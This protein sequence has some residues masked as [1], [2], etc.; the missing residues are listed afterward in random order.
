MILLAN[1][2]ASALEF[3]RFCMMDTTDHHHAAFFPPFNSATPIQGAKQA[4]PSNQAKQTGQFKQLQWDD[5]REFVDRYLHDSHSMLV[6]T[7][8]F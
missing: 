3:P 1:E 7:E 5:L 8:H 6:Q 4:E 2:V